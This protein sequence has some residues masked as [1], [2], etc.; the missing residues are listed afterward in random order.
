MLPFPI[1]THNSAIPSDLA[2]SLTNSLLNQPMPAHFQYHTGSFSAPAGEMKSRKENRGRPA[3][4]SPSGMVM[5]SAQDRCETRRVS[6][7]VYMPPGGSVPVC[8]LSC[9]HIDSPQKQECLDN[10]G[11]APEGGGLAGCKAPAGDGAL[12]SSTPMKANASALEKGLKRIR[13]FTPASAR[14]IDE[15]DE[16]RRRSP[17]IRLTPFAEDKADN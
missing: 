14:A 6:Q 4:P 3:G 7:Q 2:N 12:G 15:E 8:A 11:G 17:R 9:P 13:N 16:P 5:P 10:G 1:F